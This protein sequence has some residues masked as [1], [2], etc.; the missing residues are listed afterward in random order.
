VPDEAALK[1]REQSML[2]VEPSS[3]GVVA[4]GYTGSFGDLSRLSPYIVIT[5][6]VVGTLGSSKEDEYGYWR[7]FKFSPFLNYKLPDTCIATAAARENDLIVAP[8]N[9]KDQNP[10]LPCYVVRQEDR[11]KVRVCSLIGEATFCHYMDRKGTLKAKIK[12]D[13]DSTTFIVRHLVAHASLHLFL[14]FLHW[15]SMWIKI[16]SHILLQILLF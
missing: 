15:P 7:E 9:I 12:R 1:R 3:W 16:I 6:I 2:P 5:C 4:E 14:H 11:H 8:L 10:L 13:P